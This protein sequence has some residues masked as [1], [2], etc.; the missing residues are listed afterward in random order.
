M[1]NIFKTV[2]THFKAAPLGVAKPLLFYSESVEDFIA[3]INETIIISQGVGCLPMG[4]ESPF[5]GPPPVITRPTLIVSQHLTSTDIIKRIVCAQMGADINNIDFSKPETPQLM[6]KVMDGLAKIPLHIVHS[7][8]RTEVEF[9]TLIRKS[10]RK[11]GI[12]IV[13]TDCPY[14]PEDCL[15]GRRKVII[16]PVNM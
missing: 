9:N 10:I 11:H 8:A 6:E 7:P 14:S 2:Q 16:Q 15:R 1:N 12:G 4:V 13:L 3:Y 5:I